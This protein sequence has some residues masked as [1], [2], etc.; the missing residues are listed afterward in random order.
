MVCD[1]KTPL[2]FSSDDEIISILKNYGAK[3]QSELEAAK[4]AAEAEK[5]RAAENEAA[6]KKWQRML[7]ENLLVAMHNHQTDVAKDLILQGADVNCSTIDI[8]F[9]GSQIYN[10]LAGLT[11]LMYAIQANDMEMVEFLLKNGANR[12]KEVEQLRGTINAINF[13]RYAMHNEAIARFLEYS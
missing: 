5:K 6:K 11:P 8:D 13:A 3:T 9:I 4:A 7:S 10:S 1:G 2:D 12:W